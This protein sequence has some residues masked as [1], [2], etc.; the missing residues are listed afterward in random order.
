MAAIHI[1]MVSTPPPYHAA[2]IEVGRFPIAA[3]IAPKMRAFLTAVL[4]AVSAGGMNEDVFFQHENF[5]NG[6][7]QLAAHAAEWHPSTGLGV[8]P[9][10]PPP[11]L[12][13]TTD[14]F[15]MAR[16]E[17]VPLMYQVTRLTAG[18]KANSQS[19]ELLSG[20]G[21]VMV[22]I[23]ADPI[24]QLLARY[25]G[26]FLPNIKQP[27]L[28]I[29][30]FYVPLLDFK[31]IRDRRPE[32]LR[33]WL[34]GAKFYLRES[35]ADNALLLLSDADLGALFAQA[36]AVKNGNGSWSIQ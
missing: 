4:Q 33:Q 17:K 2:R 1:E 9:D 27:N 10:R 6:R 5:I 24:D 32:D 8:W 7:D 34:G 3:D 31:S 18:P 12:W 23:H 11:E 25:K 16:G 14:I 35:P 13:K 21:L 29:M 20:T 28:R 26:V 30:P 15:R 22:L 36:G 19:F